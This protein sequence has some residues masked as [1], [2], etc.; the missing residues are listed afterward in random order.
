LINYF[1]SYSSLGDDRFCCVTL[2]VFAKAFP[3]RCLVG[4]TRHSPYHVFINF[5]SELE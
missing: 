5:G 4:K 1:R 3:K 2:Y